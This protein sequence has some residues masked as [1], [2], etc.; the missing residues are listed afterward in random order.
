MR[1]VTSPTTC[2]RVTPAVPSTCSNS[3]PNCWSSDTYDLDCPNSGLCCFDGCHNRCLVPQE[4]TSFDYSVNKEVGGHLYQGE[5]VAAVVEEENNNDVDSHPSI[6]QREPTL[7]LHIFGPPKS[8]ALVQFGNLPEKR[9]AAAATNKAQRRSGS[10]SDNTFLIPKARQYQGP[11]CL[12]PQFSPHQRQC[13]F[14]PKNITGKFDLE[15][16]IR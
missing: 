10:S 4:T 16:I 2:P 9:L 5:E 14:L 1:P 7:V 6:N 8:K 3:R 12:P 15:K 13:Y 11:T